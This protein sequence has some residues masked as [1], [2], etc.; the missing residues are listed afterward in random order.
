MQVLHH[1]LSMLSL[2][3]LFYTGEGSFYVYVVLLSEITTP[4]VNLRW[5]EAV[6]GIEY[7][8]LV[9]FVYQRLI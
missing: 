2:S 1:L 6:R 8:N 5:Y 9:C 4:F 7:F 3:L